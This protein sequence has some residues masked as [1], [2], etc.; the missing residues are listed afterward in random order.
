M[1]TGKSRADFGRTA[2][3]SE[4]SPVEVRNYIDR[5]WQTPNSAAMI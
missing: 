3:Y 5:L 1:R 2:F 4:R